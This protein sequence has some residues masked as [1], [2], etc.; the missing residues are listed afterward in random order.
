MPRSKKSLDVQRRQ[1]EEALKGLEA[2]DAIQ[3][4]DYKPAG[5]GGLDVGKEGEAR[6][7]DHVESPQVFVYDPV[8][9]RYVKEQ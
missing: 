7:A 9:G 6:V 2:R 4:Q 8:N 3:L 5:A 1:R